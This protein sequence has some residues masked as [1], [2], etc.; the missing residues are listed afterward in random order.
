MQERYARIVGWGTYIPEKVLTNAELEKMVDTS[1][2]WIVQR[3]GIKER[4]IR[5]EKDTNTSMAVAASHEE[6]SLRR[7][8][9]GARGDRAW[10]PQKRNRKVS[11]A[12]QA[13]AALTTSAA[14][15]AVR[16]ISRR[17]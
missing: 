2:E 14:K 4:R 1:D 8:A 10:Q 3:T 6:L 7:A 13:Y 5:T 11:A 16:D 15:G 12:L 17:A 9:M